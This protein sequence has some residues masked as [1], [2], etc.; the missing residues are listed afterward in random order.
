MSRS[1]TFS[2]IFL[3]LSQLIFAQHTQFI[4]CKTTHK[5]EQ[6]IKKDPSIIE[7]RK[8]AQ[9]SMN[10][11]MKNYESN[12]NIKKSFA[13]VTVPVVIHVLYAN[14]TQNVSDAQI[15]T[16]IDV[17]NADFR[18]TNSDFGNLPAVFQAVGADVEL[19]FCLST[20]DPN[21]SATNGV[22]RTSVS[23]NFSVENNY[24][25]SNQ[26]GVPAWNRDKYLNIW[27]GDIGGGTLGFAYLP[28]GA[29]SAAEDGVVIDYRCF[30]T[31]GTAGTGGFDDFNLGRTATHE[32][33]HF[34]N[35][36]HIWGGGGCNQDDF[37]ADTPLQ[38]GE[39]TGCPSF[40]LTDNCTSGNGIMF[41]NY[42]D[43]SDDICMA[44]FT[45]GQKTRILAA[46]NGTRSG[47]LTSTGC[48]VD[49]GGGCD[50]GLV[51]CGGTCLPAP[52][53]CDPADIYKSPLNLTITFDQYAEES[54]WDINPVQVQFSTM[55]VIRLK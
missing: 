4:R 2:L 33:G 41:Q 12:D 32:V 40:P 27:V 6:A 13:V 37:V 14:G 34:F 39:S 35:L 23:A 30:G 16:Q 28:G 44:L 24:Y 29:P 22:T 55:R 45:M 43:Y 52:C 18:K 3:I 49:G 38:N 36:E 11:W 9:K 51:D 46:I 5:Y 8:Q 26:G 53:P 47:L 42:M 31:T 7:K 54:S 21:G 10:L 15:Q 1:I 50:E 19:E 25:N 20:V 48:D 17:L